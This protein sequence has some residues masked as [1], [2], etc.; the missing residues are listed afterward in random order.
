MRGIDISHYDGWP[1]KADPAKAYNDSDFIIV[2]ATQGTSYKYVDYFKP[3]I[4]KA[5]ADNKLI[6]A[7][8]YATGEDAVKE[9]DYFIS[10]VKPYIGK[11]ILA[12]DWEALQN[13]AWKKDYSWA[14]RFVDRVKAKTNVTCFLYTGMDGIQ[15][16]KNLANKV[17]LWF[18]GYPK[19]DNS[20][21]IPKW[22]S[23]YSTK[24]WSH[25]EIWQFTSGNEKV[26]RNISNMTPADW[27]TFAKATT[28]TKKGVTAQDIIDIMISWLG[29][30]RKTGTHKVLIDL[31]NS[32]TPLAQ[33]Y[34]VS[35]TD[36]WCAVT[37]SDAYIAANAVDLIGGTECS[38]QRFIDI[39]KKKG[40]WQEDGNVTPKKG[41][42]ITFNW[43]DNT[44]PNDGWADHIGIVEKVENGVIT[45]IEGNYN[46]IVARRTLKV[47]D[48]RIRGY[49]MPK[50]AEEQ[51][52]E[53]DTSQEYLLRL[54]VDTLQGKYGTGEDR[55]RKLGAYYTD[56]Q[57]IIN[58]VAKASDTELAK[59][60]IAGKYGNGD[61]RKIILGDRYAAVQK[62]VN[63]LVNG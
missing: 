45:T 50:Y 31:Y 20:W 35:Y 58:R 26:D 22:P 62:K 37:V 12:L 51:T 43:D 63:E 55:K 1:L 19:D 59:D 11:A 47:G 33:G 44:Q 57:A 15:Q 24:P 42:I 32:H 41:W 7:Y 38:V 9:A 52:I 61:T 14:K 34:K 5:L 39:F 25:Y 6:G 3:A 13:K 40:I 29:L 48:G 18:A 28:T 10:V 53:K 8:H 27:N 16:C 2:K 56:V 36:S 46:S 60:V 49:A 23:Y 21:S 30:S 54:V 17:P 4:D